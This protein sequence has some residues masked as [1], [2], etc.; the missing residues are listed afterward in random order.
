MGSQSV[1]R[2]PIAYYYYVSTLHVFFL[3]LNS[4][5]PDDGPVRTE[6]Y[7]PTANKVYTGRL[8]VV[9]DGYIN[10]ILS[11]TQRYGEHKKFCKILLEEYITMHGPPNV[12]FKDSCL[13]S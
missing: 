4:L 5:G 2:D 8:L 6:T 13:A 3:D 10:N 1:Y 9:L 11:F 12:K 7:S